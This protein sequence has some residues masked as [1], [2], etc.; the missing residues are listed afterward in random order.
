M[1]ELGQRDRSATLKGL[2]GALNILIASWSSSP[3]KLMTEV[4]LN[5]MV[6]TAKWS[7]TKLFTG[8]LE[9]DSQESLQEACWNNDNKILP[10]KYA[11][12]SVHWTNCPKKYLQNYFCEQ[13]PF[14]EYVILVQKNVDL[15]F[16]WKLWLF[17]CTIAQAVPS[18]VL[19]SQLPERL[20]RQKS[21]P[22]YSMSWMLFSQWTHVHVQRLPGGILSA[23]FHY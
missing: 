9:A 12:K 1:L 16:H 18:L 8:T 22:K 10:C 7:A 11:V 19:V 17:W 2:K 6:R 3:S 20:R 21:R 5:A 4:T 13:I 23:C 14:F 15:C